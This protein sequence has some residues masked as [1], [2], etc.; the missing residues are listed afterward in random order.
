MS[1]YASSGSSG[2]SGF[3]PASPFLESHP[4]SGG[5]LNVIKLSE[6]G[7]P[8][9]ETQSSGSKPACS[10]TESERSDKSALIHG[11]SG[12]SMDG[13]V[14][15]G[16][17]LSSPVGGV[18]SK[19]TRMESQRDEPAAP[20][21]A[22]IGVHGELPLTLPVSV[23]K[24]I[25]TLGDTIGSYLAEAVNPAP[26]VYQERIIA[27]V[28]AAVCRVFAHILLEG[29]SGTPAADKTGGWEDKC[30]R[31]YPRDCATIVRACFGQL[32]RSVVGSEGELFSDFPFAA[33][34]ERKVGRLL[35][36]MEA[37]DRALIDALRALLSAIVLKREE[38][39]QSKAVLQVSADGEASASAQNASSSSI[40]AEA[41]AKAAMR[42]VLPSV[43]ELPGGELETETGIADLK[44]EAVDIVHILYYRSES[45]RA[46]LWGLRKQLVGLFNEGHNES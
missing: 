39:S 36:R 12:G 43:P 4:S 3:R 7:R 44:Q 28:W 20:L 25:T 41:T 34:C 5:S 32:K 24:Q 46:A 15:L 23:R 27:E 22:W 40:T 21:S 33:E 18:L 14:A 6:P 35:A 8:R 10:R 17:N 42:L 31:M 38:P 30:G 9:A 16:S 45:S 29:D 37:D 26:R 1:R 2:S 19:H 13:G 11:V